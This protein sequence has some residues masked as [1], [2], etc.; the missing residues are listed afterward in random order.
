MLGRVFKAKGIPALLS[1]KARGTKR[2]AWEAEFF[3]ASQGPKPEEFLLQDLG[4]WN[5]EDP[6]K[7]LVA[8]VGET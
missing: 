5:T 3:L 1:L 6:R 2:P 4:K 8:E 7:G